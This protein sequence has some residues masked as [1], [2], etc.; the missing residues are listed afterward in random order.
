MQ[1]ALLGGSSQIEVPYLIRK[2]N[3]PQNRLSPL[4]WKKDQLPEAAMKAKH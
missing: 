4:A 3:Y 2:I 1:R